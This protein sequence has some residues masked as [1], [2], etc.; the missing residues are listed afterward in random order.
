MQKTLYTHCL[1][2]YWVTLPVLTKQFLEITFTHGDVADSNFIIMYHMH[3]VHHV[4]H[5][6]HMYHMYHMHHMHHMHHM[7]HMHH[8][9][10]IKL[11]HFSYLNLLK[12]NN[13]N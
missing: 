5:M 13:E 1:R 2:R 8:M 3:H 7:Y 12:C 9:H 10:V 4:H 6:H 11:Y